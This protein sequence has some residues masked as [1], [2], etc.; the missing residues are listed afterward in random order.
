M[1]EHVTELH[2]IMP[3]HNLPSVME[4]GILSNARASKIAHKDISM[5]EVQKRRK[6]KRVPNGLRLHEYANLYF[7]ARNPMLYRWQEE[8][9]DICILRISTDV[10]DIDGVVV[11]DRNAS[12]DYVRFL[13]PQNMDMLKFDRIYAEYWTHSDNLVDQDLHKKQK[14]AEV[15]VPHVVEMKHI[16]GVFVASKNARQK[17]LDMKFPRPIKV[18]GYIFFK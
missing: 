6:Q 4:N 1:T 11:T 13:P 2:N 9:E 10:F 7:H 3:I 17:V 5:A 12:S 8:F 15:L 16:V 18:D 14:C